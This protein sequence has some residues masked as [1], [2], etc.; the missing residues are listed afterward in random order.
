MR[1]ARTACEK[2]ARRDFEEC[3]PCAS[4]SGGKEEGLVFSPPSLHSL[5]YLCSKMK[6]T[7]KYQPR[8]FFGRGKR[9]RERE[10]VLILNIETVTMRKWTTLQTPT[11][12]PP[13]LVEVPDRWTGHDSAW[14]R[15]ECCSKLLSN[16]ESASRE[17]LLAKPRA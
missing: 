3:I 7:A 8:A 2:A 4:G 15:N 13:D 1:D 5:R 10:H 16:D 14:Q 11:G 17:H 6:R 12:Q 9:E